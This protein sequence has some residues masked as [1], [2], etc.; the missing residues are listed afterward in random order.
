[1]APG[2]SPEHSPAQ[3]G[4]LLSR[5]AFQSSAHEC[6]LRLGGCSCTCRLWQ[7]VKRMCSQLGFGSAPV[8]GKAALQSGAGVPRASSGSSLLASRRRGF[9][10]G[11]AVAALAPVSWEVAGI[12]RDGPRE[13]LGGGAADAQRTGTSVLTITADHLR[14]SLA[15]ARHSPSHRGQLHS[16]PALGRGPHGLP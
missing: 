7:A 11:K 3:R 2:R 9:P 14:L 10:V 5:M 16:L 15:D 4:R 13:T 6:S 12:P 1:M 8:G